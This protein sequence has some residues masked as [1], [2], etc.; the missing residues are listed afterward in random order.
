MIRRRVRV[1]PV[2]ELPGS[3]EEAV[4]L[5]PPDKGVRPTSHFWELPLKDAGIP[6]RFEYRPRDHGGSLG[7]PGPAVPCLATK[8]HVGHD[9]GD[10]ERVILVQLEIPKPATPERVRVEEGAGSGGTVVRWMP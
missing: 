7:P 10:P 3:S 4:R 1:E 8:D 6:V 2:S 9:A 5:L